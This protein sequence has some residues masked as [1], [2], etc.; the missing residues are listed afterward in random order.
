MRENAPMPER[1]SF[2]TTPAS[3]ITDFEGRTF[4][5]NLAILE[6][7]AESGATTA[8]RAVRTGLASDRVAFAVLGGYDAALRRLLAPSVFPRA[9][10]CVSEAGGAHP[11]AVTTQ[12]LANDDGF[13]FRVLGE[14]S[15][16]TL[17]THAD[18]YVVV[19]TKGVTAE[20]KNDLVAVVVEKGTPGVVVEARPPLPFAPE[21]PHARLI[22]TN[23]WAREVLPGDGYERYVKPFRTVEDA[24]VT[25]A[26][27]AYGI[28]EARRFGWD[29]T[30]LVSVA[31]T[32]SIIADERDATLPT[33]HVALDD[34][35]GAAKNALGALPWAEAGA[36]GERFV[37]DRAILDVASRARTARA[38]KARAA[39]S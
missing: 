5:A 12:L 39:S 20:G 35:L 18:H 33:T 8:E 1:A 22:L 10:F 37:R 30:A 28:R 15:F 24:H 32:L 34:A 26:V 27:V 7:A 16:A 2:P 14:K 4:E 25:L 29:D 17:A 13:S 23:A 21:I 11:R 6:R 3:E 31:S 19:A 38:E 36:A 9:S